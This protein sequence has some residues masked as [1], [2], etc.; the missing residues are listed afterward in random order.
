MVD[1][2]MTTKELIQREIEKRGISQK[3]IAEILGVTPAYINAILKGKKFGRFRLFDFAEKLGVKLFD[4][5]EVPERQE[6]PI[7]VISWVSAGLFSEGIDAFPVGVS[8]EG[9]PVFSRK[10]VSPQAFGLRV[11]GDSMSP[12]Y[13]PGDIIIV[14]PT[15]RCDSGCPAVVWINGDVS[16]KLFKET[17]SEIILSSTNEKYPEIVIKKD[18][19]VD[20]KIIGRVV[21]MIPK[22]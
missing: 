11:V 3:K 8:G 17:E 5:E 9:E 4:K 22:I 10:K 21:D 12:R 16:F 13:M 14:D 19:N 1:D 6:R 18:R 15:L 20:F 2:P 7:P